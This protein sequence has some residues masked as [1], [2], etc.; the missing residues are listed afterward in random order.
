[1]TATADPPL[2]DADPTGA[3]A[4]Q[5]PRRHGL[6][7][8]LPPWL[9]ALIV[10][11]ALVWATAHREPKFLEPANLVGIV[12]DQ[13]AVGILAVGM[14]LVIVAGGI[15]L[16]VGSLMVLAGGVGLTVLDRTLRHFAVI[17]PEGA[18]PVPPTV[19]HDVL[20]VVAMAGVTLAIG[21]G[22]GIVN[23]FLVAKGRLPS[24]IVTLAA[25]LALRSGAQWAANGGQFHP[26]HDSS[27]LNDVGGGWAIPHT[28]T[29]RGRRR[30]FVVPLRVPYESVV[31]A[32]VAVG[33]MVALNRT[34]LGR[35]AVAV[36]SNPRAARYSAVAVDRV[37]LTTFAISGLLAG[38]AGFLLAAKNDAVSSGGDA[39]NFELYAI[40]AAVIGGAKMSGG[41]GSVLGSIIGALLL[42]VIDKVITY[43]DV[44]SQAHG[45]VI[46][47]IIIVAAFAQRGRRAD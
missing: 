46:G 43:L 24:F 16:S 35:Y 42:G 2:A 4:V 14:T 32:A 18:A 20:A 45:V 12:R 8:R 1:M 36:G 31:W 13:S 15:D 6:G 33:G 26:T 47:A 7:L 38:V 27:V 30:N 29:Y 44:N 19:A 39:L 34:R 3:M 41:V 11:A 9:G 22:G 23:G 21:L 5:R 25:L 37:R 40:A 10:T 17:V 28:N